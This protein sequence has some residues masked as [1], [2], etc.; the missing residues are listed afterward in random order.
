MHRE[1]LSIMAHHRTAADAL[2][3]WRAAERR[4]DRTFPGGPQRALAETEVVRFRDE[5]QELLDS[6][7]EAIEQLSSLFPIP[8]EE[9]EPGSP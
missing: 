5:Y 3:D 4:R 7:A 1:G 2:A 8:R 6:E 9:P